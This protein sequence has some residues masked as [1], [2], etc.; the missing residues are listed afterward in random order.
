MSEEPLW[1][2]APVPGRGSKGNVQG[3][4]ADKN[5]HTHTG[6]ELGPRVVRGA[7]GRKEKGERAV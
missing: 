3:Y 6:D 5:M 1:D 2:S 4:L 7:G